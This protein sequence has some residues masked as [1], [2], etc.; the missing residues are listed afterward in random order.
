MELEE[1]QNPMKALENRTEASKREMDVLDGLDEIR[2]KNN[3]SERVLTRD[4]LEK[5]LDDNDKTAQE[6]DEMDSEIAA[7]FFN[8]NKKKVKSES[9]L[10]HE[11]AKSDRS[12]KD[13]IIEE[14]SDEDDWKDEEID[15][16]EFMSKN[17]IKVVDIV[18]QKQENQ[19]PANM[20]GVKIVK[21]RVNSQDD[22]SDFNILGVGYEDSD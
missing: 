8:K 9:D 4:L 16:E 14:L 12:D 11:D 17:P 7:S 1:Q 15:I 2:T 5:L 10:E 13:I 21:K 6:I 22:I 19:K 3:Q 18:K 20:L